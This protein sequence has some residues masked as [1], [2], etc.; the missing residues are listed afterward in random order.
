[1]TAHRTPTESRCFD[2]ELTW[3]TNPAGMVTAVEMP[4]QLCAFDS[5]LTPA[6]Y[7]SERRNQLYVEV[8]AGEGFAIG[9]PPMVGYLVRFTW[10]TDRA[11]YRITGTHMIGDDLH[12]VLEW[13]D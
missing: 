11:I 4:P 3:T 8:D 9:I 1:M 2:A 10:P 6:I 13:P 5:W 7:G 12:Y